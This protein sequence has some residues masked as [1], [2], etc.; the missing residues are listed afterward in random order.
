MYSSVFIGRGNYRINKILDYIF[1]KINLS[2]LQD[3]FVFIFSILLGLVAALFAILD[4]AL[5][6]AR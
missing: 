3:R 2:C 1:E 6:S 5:K 4:G